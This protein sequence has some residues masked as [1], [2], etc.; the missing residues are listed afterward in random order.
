MIFGQ[1]GNKVSHI[2]DKNP[3]KKRF[4]EQESAFLYNFS[5]IFT[6]HT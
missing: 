3:A 2:R 6:S 1:M 5:L 4:P